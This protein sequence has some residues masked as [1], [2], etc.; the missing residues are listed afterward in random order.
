[1]TDLNADTLLVALRDHIGRR[2]GVTAAALCR[3]VLGREPDGGDERQ[4][5]DV[6]TELR[7]AGHHV[8]AHPSDGYYLAE[9]AEE[10]DATCAFLYGRAMSALE[11]IAAMRRVSVPDLRGQLKLPT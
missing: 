9:T 11:Q 10:L 7:R 8:C 1:M 2:K 5:R 6:V 3:Q 4:L